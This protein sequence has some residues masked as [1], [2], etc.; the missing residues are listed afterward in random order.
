MPSLAIS[1]FYIPLFAL[2][3]FVIT[4][5]VGMFR[6]RTQTSFGDGGDKTLLKISRAQMNFS[7][8]TPIALLLFTLVEYNGASAA[9]VHGLYAVLLFG[10]LSHYLQLTSVLEPVIFRM[11]GM[12]ATLLSIVTGAVWLLAN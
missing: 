6:A 1:S 11:G 2:M 12:V 3:F 10:R 5:R 4:I 8:S 7:E 9:L